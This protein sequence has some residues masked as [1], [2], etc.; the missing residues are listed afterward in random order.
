MEAVQLFAKWNRTPVDQSILNVLEIDKIRKKQYMEL[1]V[2]Q[3]RR[4]H[5]ALALVG[6]PD[7]LFLDEPT[8]GLD[9][10][11]LSLIHI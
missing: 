8:A 6:R 2:G 4:L 9:V 3:K 7:I 1:S 5:L 11:G 10:E